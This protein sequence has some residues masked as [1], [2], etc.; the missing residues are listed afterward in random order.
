MT[1]RD[2]DNCNCEDGATPT[3]SAH[4]A[5]KATAA[6]FDSMEKISQAIRDMHPAAAVSLR[7]HEVYCDACYERDEADCS[8]TYRKSVRV[9]LKVGALDLS[10]EYAV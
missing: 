10:R 9:S 5:K 6:E 4:A 2:I 1:I 3:F 7:V 8:T